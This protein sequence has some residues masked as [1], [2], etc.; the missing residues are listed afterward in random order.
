[1]RDSELTELVKDCHALI[2]KLTEVCLLLAIAAQ[3]GLHLAEMYQ[4]RHKTGV[5]CHSHC[6]TVCQG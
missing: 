3:H 1:M 5:V 4:D 6:D 2:F